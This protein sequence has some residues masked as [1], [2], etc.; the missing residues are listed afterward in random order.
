[1]RNEKWEA[2]YS[3][4]N[5]IS[6]FGLMYRPMSYFVRK[7]ILQ[8]DFY[9]VTIKQFRFIN[10]HFAASNYGILFNQNAAYKIIA[11]ECRFSVHYNY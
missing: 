10:A 5:A 6:V 9:D 2:C 3:H 4:S 1:M 11:L 7:V 8:C